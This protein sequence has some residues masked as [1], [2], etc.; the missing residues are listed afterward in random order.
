MIRLA[1]DFET[2]ENGAIVL[3]NDAPAEALA[4]GTRVIF[5]KPDDF[6]C[7]A[8]VR[9]GAA[10][11]WVAEIVPRTKKCYGGAPPLGYPDAPRGWP[12]E[13]GMF[14]IQVDF[15]RVDDGHSIGLMPM[16]TPPQ[17]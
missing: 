2:R 1:T 14:R 8:I 10:W 15:N 7:E 16:D 4:P 12:M 3:S 6:E 17:V 9:R 13:R 11:P 5:F